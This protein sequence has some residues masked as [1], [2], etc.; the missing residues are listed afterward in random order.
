MKKI[1]TLI[2]IL[3]SISFS[4]FAQQIKVGGGLWYT[5]D[6][7]SLGISVNG[8][9]DFDD[10]WTGCFAYTYVI[11]NNYTNFSILDFD[12][13]YN[14]IFENIPIYPI[15]GLNLSFTSVKIDDILDYTEYSTTLKSSSEY[16]YPILESV[17]YSETNFGINFGV[18]YIVKLSDKLELMPELRYTVGGVNFF[19][20]G[21]KLMYTL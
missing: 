17:K 8:N 4:T 6:I 10:N 7:K 14:N 2:V 5:S 21:A 12:A 20:G 13:N 19:R 9:Y 16:E 18:G 11:K 1:F 3:T 15:L